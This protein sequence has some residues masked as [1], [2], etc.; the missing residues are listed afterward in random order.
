M[1]RFQ[2]SFKE[3]VT[4]SSMGCEYWASQSITHQG[5]RVQCVNVTRHNWLFISLEHEYKRKFSPT[6]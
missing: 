4:L 5:Y 3:T 1:L 6:V 2:H